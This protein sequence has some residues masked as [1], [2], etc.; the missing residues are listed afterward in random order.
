MLWMLLSIPQFFT[1]FLGIGMFLEGDERAVS[2]LL[3]G[4]G[5]TLVRYICSK[6]MSLI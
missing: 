2:V 3:I 1:L 5:V 4:G 6:Y